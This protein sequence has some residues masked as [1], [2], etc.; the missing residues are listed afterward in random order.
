[1]MGKLYD[2]RNAIEH[3]DDDP[4]DRSRC[5]ELL[6]FTW[7]FLRS[8]DTLAQS[9]T[10]VLDFGDDEHPQR[11]AQSYGLAVEFPHN[12][13]DAIQLTG[14]LPAAHL[15]VD[16][17]PGFWKVNLKTCE[18]K[19]DFVKR[20]NRPRKELSHISRFQKRDAFVVGYFDDANAETRLRILYFDI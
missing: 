20:V 5:E 2:L 17:E 10:A 19:A 16:H 12:G 3:R 15:S 1:M 6:E 9:K 8:T 11:S 14:W 7:Y 4:P 13:R 18:T